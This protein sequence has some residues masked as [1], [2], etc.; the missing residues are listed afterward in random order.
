FAPFGADGSGTLVLEFEGGLQ[1]PRPPDAEPVAVS[2]GVRVV[3]MSSMNAPDAG[4]TPLVSLQATLVHLGT[5]YRL[6]V[7]VDTTQG[8]T[9]TGVL[10]LDVSRVKTVITD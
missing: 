7:Q 9:R 2:L 5:R 3:D 4:G 1:T 8:M 10:L 6:P